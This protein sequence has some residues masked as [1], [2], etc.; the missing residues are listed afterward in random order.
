MIAILSPFYPYNYG[1]VLQAY[2]LHILLRDLGYDSEYISFS[3]L[4]KSTFDKLRL[5]IKYPSLLKNLFKQKVKNLLFRETGNNYSNMIKK[6][7]DFINENIPHTS[8]I[9]DFFSINEISD[10]YQYYI[11]GSDQTWTPLNYYYRIS[12]YFLEFVKDDKKKKSFSCSMGT[13]VLSINYLTFLEKKLSSFSNVCVREDYS[14]KSLQKLLNKDIKVVLDP[15]L[16]ISSEYWE[17]KETSVGIEGNFVFCYLL[18]K[19]KTIIEYSE[20][21]AKELNSKL[22]IVQTNPIINDSRVLTDIGVQEFLWLIHNAQHI[23]TDSFH[24]TIFAINFRKQFSSFNKHEENIS[25]N[26]RIGDILNRLHLSDH[27]LSNNNFNIPNTINYE[28]ISSK[29]ESL[30]IDSKDY[31][32]SIL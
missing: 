29:L 27:L 3:V 25:D 31:L 20:N 15:T 30:K 11:I 17:K 28:D 19:N 1:T 22:V 14:S 13:T 2:A 8:Q 6:N 24:G 12:P 4:P 9:Y 18:G 5:F 26:G 32:K 7:V 16:I 23:I 10:S 21:I